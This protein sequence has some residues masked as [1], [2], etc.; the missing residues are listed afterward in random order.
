MRQ[1]FKIYFLVMIVLVTTLLSAAAWAT[2]PEP[3]AASEPVVIDLLIEG[4]EL[5]RQQQ[6]EAALPMLLST[7]D[8]E[9]DPTRLH[10][11]H[12]ALAR[13]YLHKNKLD[14]ALAQV[15]AIPV[16]MRDDEARFVEGQALLALRLTREGVAALQGVRDEY[17]A[18]A[19]LSSRLQALTEGNAALGNDQ[20]A[21][22]FAHQ[23]MRSVASTDISKLYD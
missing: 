17:L 11:A 9:S 3:T 13:I 6:F 2:E 8:I 7:L 16:A 14:I 18:P 15:A 5:Y 10:Q 23:A 20:Q 19:D 1:S 22:W 4:L 21:L 12:M